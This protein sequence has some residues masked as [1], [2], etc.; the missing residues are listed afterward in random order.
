M[1]DVRMC[2]SKRMVHATEKELLESWRLNRGI[3][4]SH[5][6]MWTGVEYQSTVDRVRC[7]FFYFRSCCNRWALFWVRVANNRWS[8]WS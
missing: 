7:F 6:V 3:Q 8:A 1:D 5:R 2:D 4:Q